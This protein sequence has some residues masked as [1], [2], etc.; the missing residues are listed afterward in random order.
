M[1]IFAMAV[2]TLDCPSKLVEKEGLEHYCRAEPLEG[3]AE[4]A[5]ANFGW[6]LGKD[7][8]QR[9]LKEETVGGSWAGPQEA[10]QSLTA[11]GSQASSGGL[12]NDSN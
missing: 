4:E 8:A 2:E 7:P 5:S 6:K 9:S 10:N 3:E 11:S 12:L 1:G